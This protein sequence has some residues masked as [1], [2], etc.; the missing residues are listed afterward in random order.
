MEET[1][2]QEIQETIKVLR[3]TITEINRR[4]DTLNALCESIINVEAPSSLYSA[5]E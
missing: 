3:D 1:T 5:T 4:I 2:L